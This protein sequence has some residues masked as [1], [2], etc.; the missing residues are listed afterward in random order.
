MTYDPRIPAREICV[1]GYQ[2]ERWAL[3]KPEAIAIVFYGG[4]TWTW[5]QTLELTQRA[6]KGLQ[7]MGV[8]K[9]DHVLSWQP[10]NREAVLTWFGLNY[11]GAAYVP[12]NT[13][14]KG[15]LLQ[16]VVQLSDATLMVCHADLAPRL[17]DIDTSLL[18]DVIIT[19]G[20]TSLPNLTTHPESA[21]I[22]DQ[23]LS[24]MPEVVEPWDTQYIIF[25]S[26][27]TGPSKAANF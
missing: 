15:T 3:Q 27:T 19:K 14:Y 20:E 10:N 1:L 18:R 22:S 7:A 24:E 16:H 2:I 5:R 21:L 23:G 9:G 13:A 4:E 12:V 11:L 8:K 6:A 17:N 25:T 26:G